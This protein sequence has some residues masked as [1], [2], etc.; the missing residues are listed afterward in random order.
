MTVRFFGF[1]L[2]ESAEESVSSVKTSGRP[3]ITVGNSPSEAPEAEETSH[4]RR[5]EEN[6]FHLRVCLVGSSFTHLR[7]TLTSS[8]NN[9][10]IM[11][12]RYFDEGDFPHDMFV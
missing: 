10:N 12:Q 5:A 7:A 6:M 3:G 9:M 1:D 11:V 2:P 8:T 4:S